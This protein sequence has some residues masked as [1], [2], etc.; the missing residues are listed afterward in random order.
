M[1]FL[2]F[3]KPK[4]NSVLKVWKYDANTPPHLFAGHKGAVCS[5]AISPDGKKLASGGV[6]G[7]VRIWDL[8]AGTELRFFKSGIQP[9]N[10]VAFSPRGRF[11]ASGTGY[12]DDWDRL[13]EVKVWDLDGES[14]DTYLKYTAGVPCGVTSVACDAPRGNH[15]AHAPWL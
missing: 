1:V 3:R 2:D 5:V 8:A 15:L 6:D 13:G 10:T 12:R 4:D 11:L 14:D 9:V 7:T